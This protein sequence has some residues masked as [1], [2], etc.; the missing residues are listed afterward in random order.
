MQE[1]IHCK[2]AVS[3]SGDRMQHPFV[4]RTIETKES[5]LEHHLTHVCVACY[6]SIIQTS[7]TSALLMELNVDLEEPDR[8]D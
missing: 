8:P 1:R 3:W 5:N 7:H 4:S 6:K 2:K